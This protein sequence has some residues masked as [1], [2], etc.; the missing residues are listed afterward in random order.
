MTRATSNGNASQSFLA[1][2]RFHDFE[3]CWAGASPFGPGFC[4]G[5][6]D[7]QLLFTDEDGKALGYPVKGSLSGEAV[8]GVAGWGKWLTV[9]SR[10]DVSFWTGP[11]KEG[12]KISC[13]MFPHGAHDV[14]ATADGCFAA[15]L[16]RAGVMTIKPPFDEKHPVTVNGAEKEGLNFYRIVSLRSGGGQEVLGCAVRRAGVGATEFRWDRESHNLSTVTFDELDVV[17]IC[18]IDRGGSLA[19]AAVARNGALILLRD[20]WQDKHPIT[21]KFDN[22]T[23]TAYRLLSC[24]GHLFLLTSEAMYVLASLAG[25][26]L[27]GEPVSSVTTPMLVMP[28]EAAD[29]NLCGDRW[30]LVVMPDLVRRYD[31][32]RIHDSVPDFISP[33]EIQEMQPR[34][35]SPSWRR[36]D[37]PQS[38]QLVEATG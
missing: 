26:F 24:R 21:I 3:V 14:I 23:G 29:A 31:V 34:P 8:N 1:E 10:Q 19:V 18:A 16:G 27:A 12:D 11:E 28:F 30:L 7:G 4:F 5:S 37:I 35:I 38:R 36:K 22:V 33:G 15:P 20:V 13:V 17:D 9:T 32:G 25:R 6:E 2:I